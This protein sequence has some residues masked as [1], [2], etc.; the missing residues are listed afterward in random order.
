MLNKGI[1]FEGGGGFTEDNYPGELVY[2]KASRISCTKSTKGAEERVSG[3]KGDSSKSHST[4]CNGSF[5]SPIGQNKPKEFS[6]GPK[7]LSVPDWKRAFSVT[8]KRQDG[9]SAVVLSS[10][11]DTPLRFAYGTANISVCYGCTQ[12]LFFACVCGL[13]MGSLGFNSDS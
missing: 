10:A 6:T 8:G 11:L 9:R 12:Q 2:C 1:R 7:L 13:S 5:F 4:L 3:L